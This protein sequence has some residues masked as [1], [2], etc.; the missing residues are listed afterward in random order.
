MTEILLRSGEA[1]AIILP[2]RGGL[3]SSL[4]LNDANQKTRELL[5]LP[6]NFDK[7]SS[8]WPGGGLPFLFPFAGRV[9]HQG[10]LYKYSLKGGVYSMPLHGFSWATSWRVSSKS[11]HQVVL[12]LNSNDVS[13]GLYPF[14]FQ[15]RMTITLESSS[16]KSEVD[17]KHLKPDT[18]NATEMPVAIGWHPYFAINTSKQLLSIPAKT[19]VAVTAQGGAGKPQPAKDFLGEAPWALPKK[20]LQS[21]ILSDLR[22]DEPVKISSASGADLHMTSGP[23]EIMKHI[24][25]WTNEPTEFHCVEPWMSLPDAVSTPSGCQWLRTGESLQVW[26]KLSI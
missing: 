13:L 21:L 4:K 20:E 26:L 1:R 11:E 5:W 3:I 14:H 24:V 7:Q 19:V 15:I 16:L 12:L 9:W 8:A 10:E 18:T 6:G 23:S 22:P 25:T 17:I 2:E